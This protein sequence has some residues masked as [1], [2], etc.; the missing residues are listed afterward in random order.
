MLSILGQFGVAA[1]EAVPHLRQFR[2]ESRPFM[3]SVADRALRNIERSLECGLT[4]LPGDAEVHVVGRYRGE[5]ELDVQL[6]ESGHAVTEIE[7]IVDRTD[8]PVVLV[9]TAYDPV[10]WRVGLTDRADLAG[11]LV[12]GHHTQ[13]LLGIP[14]TLP[15]RVRSG[16][17]SLGC[18]TFAGI[19]PEDTAEIE[20]RIMALLG[21]RIDR[22]HTVSAGDYFHI[23][24]GS[25]RR[26]F[27]VVY[28]DDLK[29]EDYPVYHGDIPAGPRGLDE[30]VNRGELRL[31]TKEEI[32]AWIAGSGDERSHLH[33]GGVYYVDDAI[34]L[35]PGLYGA[36]SRDFIIARGAPRPDGPKGHCRF[37]YMKDFSKE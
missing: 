6:G 19:G 22:F 26:P 8:H 13:A 34:T 31:A 30:L 35:P 33:V 9:L 15:H 27:H 2:L 4:G 29:L 21:R 25:T 7:V 37:Y 16:E 14:A 28:S 32:D 11:V 36:H 18:D 17:Q 3:A 10:V 1:E 5:K 12:S 20:P 24:G 23:G